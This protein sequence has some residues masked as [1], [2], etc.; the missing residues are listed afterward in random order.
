MKPLF[1]ISVI[2][3]LLI[4]TAIYLPSCMKEATPP[5]VVTTIV[6]DITKTTASTG[7]T[8]TSDGG[9]E[10][11]VFG[12]CWSTS[13][14]PTV[15]SN[16]TSTG[17]GI[18]TYN[19]TI[20][21]LTENTTYYVRAFATNNA[22][23]SYGNEI[24]FKT[25]LVNKGITIPTLTTTMVISVTETSAVSGGNITDDGGGDIIARGISWNTI[26]DWNIYP[27][28]VTAD[29]IGT[30]YFVSNLSNLI[31]GTT[32]YF[33]AYAVNGVGIA[34]GSTLSFTTTIAQGTGMRKANYPGGAINGAA[35]FSIGT[36]V[37]L[38]LGY[39]A[40]NIPVKDF[41]EW[42]QATNVWTRKADYPGNFTGLSVSFSIG[43]KGYMGIDNSHGTNGFTNEFWEYNPATD[44]WS[45]KTSL[46]TTPARGLAVGFSIGTK[47]YVGLGAEQV[48]DYG[49]SYYKD[50][51]EWDQATNVWTKKADF[52]G[53]TQIDAVGF[54]IGNKGYIG[55]GWDGFDYS[56]NLPLSDFWEW[57]QAT[58]VWTRKADFEGTM[59]SAAV[60][61][62]IGNKG[63]IGTGWGGFD[64]YSSSP[65]LRDFWEW[66]QATNVWT[67]KADFEGNARS[68][69][70][71]FS[72][73][74]KGYIGMGGDGNS[75]LKDFWEYDPN[76]K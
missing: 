76:L 15:S 7:G 8:V 52:P 40:G 71:G 54:S 34:Y 43:T 13:P 63:Y 27:D 59:R 32:Y 3:I 29:R 30:G 39:K 51:W 44:F 11:I 28:E 23:T 16:K 26:P 35:G 65:P 75:N 38:G 69:A 46:P 62:S 24:S 45:Q 56:G 12:V 49:F 6:S 18:G 47:G 19:I 21:G 10:I 4:G 66:D 1:K 58:N 50:F 61:F 67:K 14:N 2:V 37:Y 22:G 72:I 60:G 68:G 53:N 74:D 36:K 20:T 57:D 55:M 17:T 42:D 31:P 9:S 5:V 33:K 70:V 25:N 73:G 64:Y 41:W 48:D